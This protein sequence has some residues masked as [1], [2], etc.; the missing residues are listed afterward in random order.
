MVSSG[1]QVDRGRVVLNASLS[2]PH[3]PWQVN[4][5]PEAETLSGHALAVLEAQEQRREAALAAHVHARALTEQGAYEEATA[6][7]SRALDHFEALGLARQAA[8]VRLAL[9]ESAYRQGRAS[10][11]YATAQAVSAQAADADDRLL[12]GLKLDTIWKRKYDYE[13]CCKSF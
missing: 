3:F 4:L 12:Q 6:S 7:F 9:A 5:S 8:R 2:P 11:A 1:K 10:E 13:S